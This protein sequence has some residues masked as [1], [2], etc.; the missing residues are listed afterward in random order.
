MVTQKAI[1]DRQRAVYELK[2]GLGRLFYCHEVL[3]RSQEV[4]RAI[5]A[6]YV[7]ISENIIGHPNV[8]TSYDVA[9]M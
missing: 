5:S 3:V 8:G 6:L 1:Q 9:F 4:I 2:I 7:L